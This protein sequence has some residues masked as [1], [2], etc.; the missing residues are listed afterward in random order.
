M[1]KNLLLRDAQNS[2]H[3]HI[4]L[5]EQMRDSFARQPLGERVASERA[6][7][8]EFGVSTAT[9]SR[10]LQ[11]LQQEG[12]LQRIP[13][14]GTFLSLP[15][16][17]IVPESGGPAAAEQENLAAHQAVLNA[18]VVVLLD[19]YEPNADRSSEFWPQRIVSR[20]EYLIG[21]GGGKGQNHSGQRLV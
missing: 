20:L 8:R 3:L 2:N 5:R 19:L 18:W 13:G 12:I 9:V 16:T 17:T 21:G 15:A 7:A 11:E 14:K 1:S 4:V 6:L 10:A